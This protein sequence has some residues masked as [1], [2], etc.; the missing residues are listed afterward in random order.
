[1][2]S[3]FRKLANQVTPCQFPKE[4]FERELGDKLKALKDELLQNETLQRSLASIRESN[5]TLSER[6]LAQERKVSDLQENL[7]TAKENELCL[8]SQI[9]LLEVELVDL[10]SM[11]IPSEREQYRLNDLQAENSSLRGELE[12]AKGELISF[13][14]KLSS[15]SVSEQALRDE[16]SELRV[17]WHSLN[18]QFGPNR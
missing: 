10:K 6:S 14:N 13:T 15:A 9:A 3:H 17:S 2:N 8:K 16:I 1:M 4:F 18:G 11:P 7:E 12:N 5:A